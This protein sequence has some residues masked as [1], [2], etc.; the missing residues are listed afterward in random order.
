MGRNLNSTFR[1]M[2]I[3]SLMILLIK[4]AG[5]N[6]AAD[7]APP[8]FGE[9][10]TPDFGT[11]GDPFTFAIP[12]EDN[13]GLDD[14]YVEYWYGSGRSTN[15]SMEGLMIFTG[16]IDLLSGSVLNLN[17]I[18][19]AVDTSG[20]WAHTDIK[21]VIVR[22]NDPP[23]LEMDLTPSEI[24]TGDTL[25]FMM[26]PS[27]NIGIMSASVE[28]WFGEGARCNSSIV[29]TGA[30]SWS[31]MIPIGCSEDVRYIFHASDGSGNWLTTPLK[32]VIVEDNVPPSIY[33]INSTSRA[34]MNRPYAI[35]ITFG[36]NIGVSKI[37]VVY[38]FDEGKLF[39]ITSDQIGQGPVEI[40]ISIPDKGY[41][42]LNYIVQV[43]DHNGNWNRSL[44][45]TAE[46]E[47]MEDELDIPRLIALSIVTIYILVSIV[48]FLYLLLRKGQEV[49]NYYR[50]DP[51]FKGKVFV[52][53][54]SSDKKIA[55][56]ISD[57]LESGGLECWIAPRDVVPG[58][59]YGKCIIK[60]IKSCRIM[61]LV[62]SK[63]AD[64]SPQV[65]REVERAVSRGVRIIPVRVE[66]VIPSED[67]EYFI[68]STHWLDLH[69]S[70]LAKV[71]DELIRTINGPEG[72]SER[73]SKP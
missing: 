40:D 8:V 54:T 29:K 6:L 64:S 44:T 45:R 46:I 20:N 18:F 39:N 16:T 48:I 36:D 25:N 27:D 70:S 33:F 3:L 57:A 50:E 66:D 56:R 4:M 71:V 5:F 69:S 22:D 67:M 11:T 47:N 24:G 41:E 21:E 31:L 26:V 73:P 72:A 61:V 38:W 13:E 42:K 19:H 35:N 23:V 55:H 1:I 34:F 59:N 14:V 60:A 43:S 51:N 12:V 58:M 10:A 30:Y 28:Y 7:T 37:S 17:Y 32:N 63:K 49:Y 15:I 9:D 53:Y 65:Q 68:S 52:S 62:Y 2:L